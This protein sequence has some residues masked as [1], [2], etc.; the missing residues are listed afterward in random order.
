M[1][2]LVLETNRYKFSKKQKIL[3]LSSAALVGW[4]LITL[5]DIGWPS[6][7]Q[8]LFMWIFDRTPRHQTP[9][10]TF[11]TGIL[12]YA[13]FGIPIAIIGSFV[14]GYPIWRCA[15]RRGFSSYVDSMKLGALTALILGGAGVIIGVCLGLSIALDPNA[16]SST[17]WWGFETSRDGL[18]TLLGWLFTMFD[19]ISTVL[20]GLVA[21]GV[22]RF[23]A[24]APRSLNAAIQTS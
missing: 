14:I 24:G 5:I 12:I 3:G 4:A 1:I 11:R 17:F 19:M 18:P 23:A 10:E 8:I 6:V 2:G 13:A 22:A 16:S 9:W 7:D 20:V 15:E 21:G